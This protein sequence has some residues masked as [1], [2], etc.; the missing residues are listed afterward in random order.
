MPV[1][2]RTQTPPASTNGTPAT[3]PKA[4]A[5]TG[6]VPIP[7]SPDEGV[8]K[9]LLYEEVN[10]AVYST[11]KPLGPITLDV[12]VDMLGWETEDQY[13]LRKKV[14]LASAKTIIG[15][16]EHYLLKDANSKKVNCWHNARNRPF[17]EAHAKALAQEILNSGPLLP[18]RQRRWKLNG[19]A[20]I[21]G[22]Y[23]QV[24]SGQHRLIGLILA[25]QEWV[26]NTEKWDHIWP[27]QPFIES[28]VSFGIDEEEDTTRTMDNVKPR[29]LSDVFYTSDIFRNMGPE[30]RKE[31]SR[32]LAYAVDLLWKRTGADVKYQ[33]HGESC[34]FLDRHKRL[35][36]AVRD[37]Y[38]DNKD[39]SISTL[40]LSAGHCAALMYLMASG[41]SDQDSYSSL[42]TE[43]CLDFSMWDKAREFFIGLGSGIKR[44][45]VV[46]E[47][48]GK[49]LDLEDEGTG[50]VVEKHGVLC[51]AWD[52][53]LRNEEFT[54]ENLKV[55]TGI[56]E[57][58]GNVKLVEFPTVGGIDLGDHKTA[59]SQDPT[60]EELEAAK[61]KEKADRL[62]AMQDK[63]KAKVGGKKKV[64][65]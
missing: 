2:P 23:G 35:L 47:A 4:T 12:A 19:E 39:R 62:A 16:G 48:L 44:F 40:K 24:L 58:T 64:V 37:L 20:I 8:E 60:P 46:R 43:T 13:K 26:K 61:A 41:K 27:E 9:E 17:T 29:V 57:K 55:A 33:T 25:I 65:A 1:L 59:K 14:G 53:F 63:V 21:I 6:P 15:Y 32:Y 34:D 3:K 5:P 51:K 49:V 52:F 18:K 42:R 7:T 54:L 45:D 10:V 56:D 38:G 31:S 22:Q 36:E 28:V 50:S 30:A 11:Q